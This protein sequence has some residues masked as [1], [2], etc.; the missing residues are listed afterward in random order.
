MGKYHSN[1]Y[2]PSIEE[3]EAMYWCNQ[4]NIAVECFPLDNGTRLLINNNGKL[5]SGNKIWKYSQQR[6][7]IFTTYLSIYK[8]L[9]FLKY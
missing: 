1:Y 9:L 8:K 7:A 3:F 6:E 5:R 2:Q 4:R